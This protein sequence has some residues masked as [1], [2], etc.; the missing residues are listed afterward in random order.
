MKTQSTVFARETKSWKKPGMSV[1]IMSWVLDRNLE[2]SFSEL[3]VNMCFL[4]TV[5]MTCYSVNICCP[6]SSEW[7]DRE[8]SGSGKDL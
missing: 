2:T 1:I 5:N 8:R 3:P 7:I 6:I 4:C